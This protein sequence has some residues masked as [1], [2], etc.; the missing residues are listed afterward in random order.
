MVRIAWQPEQ[1]RFARISLLTALLAG[2]GAFGMCA[3]L[4]SPPI[5]A[6]RMR[7]LTDYPVQW[8]CSTN[9]AHRV[10][11]PGRYEPLPCPKCGAPS[12]ILLSYTCRVHARPAVDVYVQF[13]RAPDGE[14]VTR[15]RFDQHEAWR[16]SADGR[17]PCPVEG[18][19]EFMIRPPASWAA[20]EAHDHT[21]D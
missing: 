17:V 2:L 11:A 7:T 3:Y 16:D 9:S 4:R 14:R 18:C 15:Y 21:G 6:A 19:T 5:P 20:R 12:D 8:V 13:A 10:T 1:R